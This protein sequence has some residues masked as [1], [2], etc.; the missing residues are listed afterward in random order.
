MK[1]LTGCF[2]FLL[3]LGGLQVET[4]QAAS[5]SEKGGGKGEEGF[6]S[7][8]DGETLKGWTPYS[9]GG[10]KVAADESAFSVQDG[11]IRCSGKGKDYWLV[12]DGIYGDCILRLEFKLTEDANSGVFLRVPSPPGHPAFTGFEVQILDDF[13]HEGGQSKKF[14]PNK[15]STGSIYDVLTPMRNMSRPI[16]EWNDMEIVCKGSKVKVKHNGCTVIGADFSELVEPIG[17][18]DFPYSEIPK[19]GLIGLQNHGR[20]LWFR[21]IRIKE[22]K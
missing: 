19:E 21:N 4:L 3:A 16:G 10:E 17:K 15:H 8:F 6:V 12:A 14:E 9:E 2:A 11:L 20:E 5:H 13:K 1:L 18:F 22:L 7:L